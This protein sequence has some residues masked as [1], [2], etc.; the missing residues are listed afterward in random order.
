MMK[1]EKKNSMN[2]GKI[3]AS[4]TTHKTM[5]KNVSQRTAASNAFTN[6]ARN[7]ETAK[8]LERYQKKRQYSKRNLIIS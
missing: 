6:K 8:D 3:I 5:T 1:I 4:C 7:G 2:L